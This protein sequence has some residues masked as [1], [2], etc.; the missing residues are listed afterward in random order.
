MNLYNEKLAP[1][2]NFPPAGE[3]FLVDLDK[4][5]L[6]RVVCN[7]ST[8]I[9]SEKCFFNFKIV[10]T[11]LSKDIQSLFFIDSGEILQT[12]STSNMKL[13]SLSDRAQNMSARGIP[14]K[15]PEVVSSIN[16]FLDLLIKRACRLFICQIIDEF[17]NR[18]VDLADMLHQQ[19]WFTVHRI[20][21]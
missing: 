21:K 17:G 14:C 18:I 20:E 9:L 6:H 16:F 12:P 15:V 11:L 3:V 2:E 8:T 4:D 13:F 1:L 19:I 7:V 10:S 5:G